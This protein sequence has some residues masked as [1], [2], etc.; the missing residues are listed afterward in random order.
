MVSLC[1]FAIGAAH[2]L[3]PAGHYGGS[4]G[5]CLNVGLGFRFG[6]V[7]R[8]VTLLQ[9]AGLGRAS[10]D[11]PTRVLVWVAPR[12]TLLQGC[13]FWVAPRETLLQ[14]AGLGRASGDAPTTC[15]F[16]VAPRETLLQGAG[17]GSRLGR[18]SYNV[19]VGASPEARPQCLI[20]VVFCLLA[21]RPLNRRDGFQFLLG[22]R[23]LLAQTA[24]FC[25]NLAHAL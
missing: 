7:A 14:G 13:W 16:W 10:G 21:D 17:F 19:P 24:V 25:L 4:G 5:I 22:I 18:R 11:A 15:W 8:Q 3:M 20:A 2:R 9:G 23:E 1:L 12:E 6:V